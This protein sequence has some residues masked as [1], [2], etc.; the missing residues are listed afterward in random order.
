MQPH[1]SLDEV[2]T[3]V[4]RGWSAFSNN[5]GMFRERGKGVVRRQ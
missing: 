3:F 1:N 5:E 4:D 2:R